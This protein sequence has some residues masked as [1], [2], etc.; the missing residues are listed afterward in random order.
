MRPVDGDK[1]VSIFANKKE[2][3]RGNNPLPSNESLMWLAA[4]DIVSNAPTVGTVATPGKWLNMK[5]G[6]ADCSVCGRHIIGVYDDDSADRYFRRC[7]A[8]MDVEV[9]HESSGEH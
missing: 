2:I 9:N 6:N 7:G 3:W 8:K 4:M 5:D 1:L